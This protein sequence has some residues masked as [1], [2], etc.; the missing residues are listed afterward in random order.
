MNNS[1]YFLSAGRIKH[2]DE[3]TARPNVLLTFA[4]SPAKRASPSLGC[5]LRYD[6]DPVQVITVD[7]D[8]VHVRLGVISPFYILLLRGMDVCWFYTTV[9]F[10]FILLCFCM[11][12]FLYSSRDVS[13]RKRKK[14]TLRRYATTSTR[15]YTLEWK[16]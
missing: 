14:R 9:L 8:C 3:M 7:H 13:N 6:V 4:I 16:N 15:T 2:R 10:L 11:R 1:L 12:L 5:S